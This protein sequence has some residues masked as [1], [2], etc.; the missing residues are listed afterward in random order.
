METNPNFHQSELKY[1]W[2]HLVLVFIKPKIRYLNNIVNWIVHSYVQTQEYKICVICGKQWWSWHHDAIPRNSSLDQISELLH[3]WWLEALEDKRSNRWVNISS[4]VLSFSCSFI[5]HLITN[6]ILILLV[7][8]LFL[9]RY[10][11]TYSNKMTFAT[12]KESILVWT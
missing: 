1:K 9:D 7:L 3:H 11:R 8:F 2:L 12:I 4:Y 10:T 5:F 6:F